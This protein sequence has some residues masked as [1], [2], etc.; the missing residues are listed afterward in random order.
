[1]IP[2]FSNNLWTAYQELRT[3]FEIHGVGVHLQYVIDLPDLLYLNSYVQ[4]YRHDPPSARR[5]FYYLTIVDVSRNA[6]ITASCCS[7]RGPDDPTSTF[8]HLLREQIQFLLQQI[9]EN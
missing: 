3:L 7:V 1:M 5:C 8:H 9:R 4:R 2:T 6:Y